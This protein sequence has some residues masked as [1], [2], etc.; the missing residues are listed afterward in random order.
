MAVD[1][2]IVKDKKKNLP[3]LLAH[4]TVQQ[5][6]QLFALIQMLPD[7]FVNKDDVTE[8]TTKSKSPAVLVMDVKIHFMLENG[9]AQHLP[10]GPCHVCLVNK[11]I[12]PQVL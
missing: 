12:K 9:I 3:L 7:K 10:V 5:I 1:D 2:G 6:A 4:L 11:L 8:G